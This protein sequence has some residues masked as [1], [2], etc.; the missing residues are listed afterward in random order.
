MLFPL[1]F[2]GLRVSRGEGVFLIALYGVYIASWFL[3]ACDPPVL[4]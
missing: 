2:T 1:M 4:R 3:P